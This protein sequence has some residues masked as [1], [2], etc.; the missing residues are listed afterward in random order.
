M[1]KAFLTLG[2]LG[3]DRLARALEY[4]PISRPLRHESPGF[5]LYRIHNGRFHRDARTILTENDR[6]LSSFSA[7]MGCGPRDNWLFK[8]VRLGPLHRVSGKSLL[9][10]GQW[11]YYHFLIEEI[12]RIWLASEAG[13]KINDFDHIIMFSPIHPS[14]QQVCERLG[15]SMEKI[16]PLEKLQHIESE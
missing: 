16:V 10:V 13:F 12:P 3:R 1:R 9:L 14:Q 8:K 5:G 7:W 15:I 6:V 2:R 4:L 11:N